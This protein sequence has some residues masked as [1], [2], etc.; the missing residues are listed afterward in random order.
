MLPHAFARAALLLL[1]VALATAASAQALRPGSPDSVG[2]SAERLERLSDALAR[3]SSR[4]PADVVSAIV[5][6]LDA[7]AGGEEPDDDQTLVITALE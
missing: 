6:E 2:L 1:A 5:G 7:F 3:A 4:N